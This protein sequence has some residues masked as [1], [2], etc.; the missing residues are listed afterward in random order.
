[1]A[2]KLARAIADAYRRQRR[3]GNTE[4]ATAHC[5]IVADRTRP[6]VWDSNHADTVTAEIECEIEAL[7]AATDEHLAQTRWR[8]VQPIASRPR[9]FSAV[10]RSMASRSN[11]PRSKWCRAATSRDRRA[12]IDPCP[13]LDKTDRDA[14]L[15]L[16]LADHAEGRRTNKLAPAFSAAVVAAGYRREPRKCAVRTPPGTRQ[17]YS[18]AAFA[19]GGGAFRSGPAPSSRCR[20]SWGSPAKRR[21]ASA[22]LARP[23]AALTTTSTMVKDAWKWPRAFNCS[24]GTPAALSASA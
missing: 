4:S 8:V 10:S 16:G 7:F 5:H 6:E 1:M 13:V 24:T 2:N 12:R 15:R 17:R 22:I 23:P 3:L 11:P 9:R 20:L 14:L 21:S 19:S 18:A